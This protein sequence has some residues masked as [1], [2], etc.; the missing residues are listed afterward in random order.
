[1]LIIIKSLYLLSGLNILVAEDNLI[2]QKIANYILTKQGAI[3]H[4]AL[5]GNDAI[6]ILSK[7][8]IDVILMDLQM[9]GMDGLEAAKYIRNELKNNI[10]IIALTADIFAGGSNEIAEAGINACIAKPFE[11]VQLCE[12]ILGLINNNEHIVLNAL[13]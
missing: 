2:N 1:M 7:N 5:N 4:T 9:P 8:K 10:P 11:P 13:K 3:V 12:L 6:D